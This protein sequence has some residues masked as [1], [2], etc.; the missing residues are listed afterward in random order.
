MISIDSIQEN[1]LVIKKSKFYSFVFP[2][3]NEY[4]IKDILKGLREKYSDATHVCSAY[5]LSS[6]IIERADDDGEPSGTAGKPLLELLKKRGLNNVLLVVVRY[7]GGVK[8]GAGGLV[9]AYT[10]AG[11]IVLDKIKIIE[12]D[13]AGVY[14][15]S[16]SLDKGGKLLDIVKNLAYEIVSFGYAD[17]FVIEFV[18]DIVD[19]L[20]GQMPEIVIEKIGSKTVCL[21]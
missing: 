16:I 15:C 7:F 1:C 12:V 21:K 3:T 19:T 2:V 5:K 10:S 11:N 8:L 18:G 9:R 14:R 13:I 6:P 4:E 17:K 20:R